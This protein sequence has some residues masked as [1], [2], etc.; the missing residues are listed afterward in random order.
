[1]AG[2][3]LHDK[4]RRSDLMQIKA[5]PRELCTNPGCQGGESPAGEAMLS[6]VLQTHGREATNQP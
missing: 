1:M 5:F 6:A 3:S 2:R 4:G